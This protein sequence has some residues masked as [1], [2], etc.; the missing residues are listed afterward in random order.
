MIFSKPFEQIRMIIFLF[1]F[2]S[3]DLQKA[4]NE[5]KNGI[6]VNIIGDGKTALHVAAEYGLCMKLNQF[7][8]I[9]I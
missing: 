4:E 3:D 2:M 1:D 9:L 8:F 6:D 5:V 7:N